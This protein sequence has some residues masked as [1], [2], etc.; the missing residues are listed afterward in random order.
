MEDYHIRIGKLIT[1]LRTRQN[2]TQTE[3]A[4]KLGTSQSAINRIEKGSQNVSLDILSRLSSVL[5]CDIISVGNPNKLSLCVTGGYKLSQPASQ[6]KLSARD[7]AGIITASLITKSEVALSSVDVSGLDDFLEI[8]KQLGGNID[9]AK[10]NHNDDAAS[11]SISISS[12]NLIC[13]NLFEISAQKLTDYLWATLPLLSISSGI[14]IIY[15]LSANQLAVVDTLRQ[16]NIKYRLHGTT[17]II[18]GNNMVKANVVKITKTDTFPLATI[19]ALLTPEQ[20][21]LIDA[22]GENYINHQ[23]YTALKSF[24]A[25]IETLHEI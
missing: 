14:S 11:Y 24:G 20:T 22:T 2:W 4:K 25:Q 21:S 19:L 23:F 3:L 18:S 13:P 15:D 10:D 5:D 12:S 6:L 16:F 8:T 9:I 1:D 17:L 7:L